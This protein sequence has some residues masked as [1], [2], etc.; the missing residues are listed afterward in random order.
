[1]LATII[2]ELFV[3]VILSC[4][5]LFWEA[6]F[7]LFEIFFSEPLGR[8]FGAVVTVVFELFETSF[9]SCRDVFLQLL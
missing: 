1:M 8:L 5:A 4:R 7:E 3:T 9:R 2:F 6:I